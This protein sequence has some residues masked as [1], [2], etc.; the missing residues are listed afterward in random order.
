VTDDLDRYVQNDNVGTDEIIGQGA[1]LR[2]SAAVGGLPKSS[3]QMASENQ[4]KLE[5]GILFPP[6]DESSGRENGR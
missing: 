4:E 3:R 6:L 2:A 5:L 1:L